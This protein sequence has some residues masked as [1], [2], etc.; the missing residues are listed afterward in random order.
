MTAEGRDPVVLG[1]AWTPEHVVLAG[2]AQCVL[3]SLRYHARRTSVDHAASASADGAVSQRDEDGMWAVVEL[4]VDVEVE[5][6]PLPPGDEVEALLAS[7]ERGCFVGASLRPAPV[8]RWRVNGED[9]A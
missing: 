3:T 2:L 6:D 7:A 9:I 1:E 5:L 8:Y 4:N